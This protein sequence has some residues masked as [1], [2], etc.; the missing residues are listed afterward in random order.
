MVSHRIA[1]HNICAISLNC[2]RRCV[3]QR[4]LVT[5]LLILSMRHSRSKHSTVSQAHWRNKSH[6]RRKEWQCLLFRMTTLQVTSS[7]WRVIILS[8][9][10]TRAC[11]QGLENAWPKE[12]STRMQFLISSACFEFMELRY[13]MLILDLCTALSI[14]IRIMQ[15]C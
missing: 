11:R 4:R 12:I 5:S 10:F 7:E 8:S 14:S 9:I 6:S 13:W 2:S 1:T 3:T 15:N